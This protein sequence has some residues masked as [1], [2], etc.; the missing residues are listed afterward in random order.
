MNP[1]TERLVS[2]GI[3]TDALAHLS[4]EPR[5]VLKGAGV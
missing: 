1:A 3:A 2:Q 5:R 4:E